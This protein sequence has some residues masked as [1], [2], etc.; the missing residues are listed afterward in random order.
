MAAPSRASHVSGAYAADD[1]SARPPAVR[2]LLRLAG[3]LISGCSAAIAAARHARSQRQISAR[4]RLSLG[5]ATWS[6]AKVVVIVPRTSRWSEEPPHSHHHLMKI[7]RS[8]AEPIRENLK[9][10][11]RWNSDDGG[12]IA[13]WERGREMRH[14]DPALA[15]KAHQGQL[16]VL[17][18][19]GG[20]EKAIKKKQKYGSLL[21]FAMWQGLRGEDLAIDLSVEISLDCTTTGMRVVF[22]S[23]P[24]KYAEA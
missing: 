18:W 21:Y 13:S 22:T 11:E 24:S 6:G 7:H 9:W 3:N 5:A 20:V 17:P 14:E 12:L 1:F 15:T 23:D 8:I 16:V 2:A 19:K 10:D 4:S